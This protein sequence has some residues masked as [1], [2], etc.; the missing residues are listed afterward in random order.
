MVNMSYYVKVF[1]FGANRKV[2]FILSQ[3][4]YKR[5]EFLHNSIQRIFLFRGFFFFQSL[6]TTY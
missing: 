2:T 1:L 4:W 6:Q 5:Y 3:S